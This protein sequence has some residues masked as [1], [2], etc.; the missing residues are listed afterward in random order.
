MGGTSSLRGGDSLGHVVL[1]CIKK[2][3]EQAIGVASQYSFMV[4]E[5]VPDSFS[6]SL[7]DGL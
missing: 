5:S 2:Q 7:S 6:A 1:G 3:A 4:C